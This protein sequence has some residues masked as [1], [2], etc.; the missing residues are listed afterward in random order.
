MQV[1]NNALGNGSLTTALQTIAETASAHVAQLAAQVTTNASEIDRVLGGC[2]TFV[3]QTRV[4]NELAKLKLTQE[5]DALQIRF[6]DVVQFVDGVPD[7]VG[8]LK[9]R[10]ESITSWLQ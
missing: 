9:A 1:L 5:V 3:E 7:K 8:D 4:D 6:R 2:R 10:L